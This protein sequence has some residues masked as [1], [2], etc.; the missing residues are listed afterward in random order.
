MALV[1][2]APGLRQGPV[3]QIPSERSI[4]QLPNLV[5][6]VL[7]PEQ[8]KVFGKIFTLSLTE[9]PMDYS[10]PEAAQHMLEHI[11]IPAD[12]LYIRRSL[13]V[14]DLVLG[15]AALFSPLRANRPIQRNSGN[16]LEALR[17]K[18][19]KENCD[20]CPEN[21]E[22][23]TP[24]DSF[25]R[26]ESDRSYT[27]ANPAPYVARHGLVIPRNVHDPVDLTRE[28]LTDMIHVGNEWLQRA[29]QENP[30]AN[31]PMMILNVLPRAGGSVFHP[32]LQV[33][34]AENK[35]LPRVRNY[36]N[37]MGY[38]QLLNHYPYMDEVA[39][40]LRP[41]G[42]VH[43]LGSAHIIMDL[44]PVKEKG[45]VIY[46]NDGNPF[47]NG[48]LSAAVYA[49]LDWQKQEYGVTSSNMAVYMRPM[50]FQCEKEANKWH[51]FFPYAR[52]V[53]RGS[54]DARTADVGAMEL[55][56]APVIAAD[57]LR[58]SNSFADYLRQR[59]GLETGA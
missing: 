1:D 5:K 51:N 28:D 56:Y 52:T 3:T 41:L 37:R 17:A 57:P 2:T 22:K 8:Q 53:D 16:Q 36:R 29:H 43:D 31:Y 20:F 9:A 42:L 35:P 11:H 18:N 15:T 49:V 58:L 14:E 39:Y 48:D 19:P 4:L 59:S 25:G 12:C 45:V 54:E 34:L 38:Y 47:P 26:I 10:T 50:E 7:S 24:K 21:L 23:R 13:T 46:T 30:R 44:T 6:E 32:H 33:M 27:A 40:C 55:F